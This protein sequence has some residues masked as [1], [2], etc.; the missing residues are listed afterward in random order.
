MATQTWGHPCP[1]EATVRPMAAQEHDQE[2][3]APELGEQR[4]TLEARLME[5]VAVSAPLATA[6]ERG[7]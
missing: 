7:G 1:L 2:I 3:P 6:G 4:A 5:P